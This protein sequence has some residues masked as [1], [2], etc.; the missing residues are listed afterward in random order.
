MEK[1]NFIKYHLREALR[2]AAAEADGDEVLSRRLR[3]E[4]RLR[5]IGLCDEQLW[6]LANKPHV[7]QRCQSGWP[8]KGINGDVVVID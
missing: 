5:L 8:T 2:G 3:A 6:E 4:A 7:L 1:R